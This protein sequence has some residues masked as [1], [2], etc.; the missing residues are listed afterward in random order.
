MFDID[1]ELLNFPFDMLGRNISLRNAS[2]LCILLKTAA[3]L[4]L[5]AYESDRFQ[6]LMDGKSS[7]AGYSTEFDALS[8]SKPF[9]QVRIYQ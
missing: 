9:S 6:H 3:F 1:R 2:L 4:L 8:K 5:G 7:K